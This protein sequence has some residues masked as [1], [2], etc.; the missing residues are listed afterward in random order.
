MK[1]RHFQRQKWK[2]LFPSDFQDLTKNVQSSLGL[3]KVTQNRTPDLQKRTIPKK[4]K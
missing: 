2:N 3:R 1:Y 4:D